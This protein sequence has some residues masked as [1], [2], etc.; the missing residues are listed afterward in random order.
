M[1]ILPFQNS[2]Q[3]PAI[4][5]FCSGLR[6]DLITDLSRFRSF[7]LISYD[8]IPSTLFGQV[9]MEEAVAKL[10]LDYYVKGHVR[11]HAEQLYF[12]LQLIKAEDHRLVWAEKFAGPFEKLFQIQEE[13]VEKIVV[14][15]QHFV[16]IDLLAAM[17]RKPLT[18]LNAYECW[19]KGFQEVKKGSISAD[20]KARA[21]FQ[22]AIDLDPYYARAY[23]GMSLTYFNEWSCQLWSRWEVSQL[24]AMEWAKKA[25]ELDEWD[26]I[27]MTIL[28]RLYL[29]NEEYDKAEH[30]LRKALRTNAS[31]A[32]NLIQIACGLTF[33]GYPKEAYHLYEKACLLKPIDDAFLTAGA[34]IL[35]ELG[36]FEEALQLG[37]RQENGVGWVDFS[38]IMA[39]ACYYQQDF[40]RMQVYWE[41]FVQCFQEKI[42]QGKPATSEEALQ[43]TIDVNPYKSK[44]LLLEFWEYIGAG[45]VQ[46]S[47]PTIVNAKMDNQLAKDG[48]LW[49]ARFGGEEVQL[50][51]VKGY[52]DLVKLLARPYQGIHCTELM[53]ITLIQKGEEVFDEKAK[54]SYQ[55]RITALQGAI[56]EAE[57][58]QQ[59]EQL[60]RLR[61]EYDQLLAHLSQSVGLG[62]RAR[63]VSGTI[64][65]A[66]TAVTWRIRS[67]I[68]RISQVH[69]ALGKHLK[70]SIKTGL[71]CEY[72]PEK[73][74]N[75]SVV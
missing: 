35:F 28:G 39:A 13:M 22:Q 46:R 47:T 32:E 48:E 36:R 30:Y 49:V 31:D 9:E 74:I 50:K 7:H 38:A 29:Y 6:L 24:G 42:K 34:F 66:R 57:F 18:N 60:E 14:S 51:E 65:K 45:E 56:A 59:M 3:L 44:T 40:G 63:K 53:N 43:W 52:H 69:P 68:K 4:D 8:I 58:L 71:V 17:R 1:A 2:A 5:M 20:E 21:Y 75:W 55:Q 72:T 70:I 15:L 12:N 26:H 41:N 62:G 19:I 73:E 33:L 23:T 67:A 25:L 61:E 54:R 11:C 16:D 64:E 27:S 10:K 37:T